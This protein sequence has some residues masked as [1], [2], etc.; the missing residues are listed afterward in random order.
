[1][2]A[3][4]LVWHVIDLVELARVAEATAAVDA[5]RTL[6]T[7]L[8]SP[9]YH[10][11]AGV[12]H[13]LR[14]M[15]EGRLDEAEHVTLTAFQTGAGIQ[16]ANADLFF[17]VQLLELRWHQGRLGE[18]EDS[19][20]AF[21][22]QFPGIPGWRAALAFI[23]SEKGQPEEARRQL[24]VLAAD[25]F[26]RVPRDANLLIS[27]ALLSEVCA[28]LGDVARAAELAELAAPY[29][30][31]IVVVG[32]GAACYGAVAYFLGR[33]ATAMQRP[34]AA[35]AHL[36]TALVTHTHMGARPHRALV[37]YRLAELLAEDASEAGRERSAALVARALS[38]ARAMGMRRLEALAG[39]LADRL[40]GSPARAESIVSSERAS[41]ATRLFRREGSSGAS[42]DPSRPPGCPPAWA[43]T[44]SRISSGMAAG[45]YWRRTWRR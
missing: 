8:R 29:A 21:V 5:Y 37:E 16:G 7:E 32:N 34:D 20:R 35:R 22:T 23:C 42:A 27:L 18:L 45:T 24:E 33:L 13:A 44:T 30:D 43:S 36:E 41:P 31:R 38:E 17:G 25:G 3:G 1:M 6:A 26:A 11:Q 12:L 40:A 19:V 15:I 2:E 14:C 28:F 10:W 9:Y 39:A 4:A